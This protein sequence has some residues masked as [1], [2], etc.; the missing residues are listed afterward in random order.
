MLASSQRREDM[1]SRRSDNSARS[2]DIPRAR[3]VYASY[4]DRSMD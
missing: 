3:I 1:T 4:K 2:D